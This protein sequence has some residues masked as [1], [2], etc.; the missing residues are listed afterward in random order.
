MCDHL[1]CGNPITQ[2]NTEAWRNALKRAGFRWHDFGIRLQPGTG[3]QARRRT[4]SA[5]RRLENAVDA[6][7]VRAY[8]PEGLQAAARRLD[9]LFR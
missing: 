8:A 1:I 6:G 5:A 9:S 4:T 3:R 7:A 2:V